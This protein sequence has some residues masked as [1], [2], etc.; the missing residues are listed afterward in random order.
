MLLRMLVE[1]SDRTKLLNNG[2]LGDTAWSYQLRADFPMFP[3]S[4]LPKLSPDVVIR[5]PPRLAPQHFHPFPMVHLNL[6][7]N[8]HQT[9]CQIIVVFPHQPI[10]ELHVVDI[11]EYERVFGRVEVFG[12]KKCGGVI[13]PVTER[14]E[15]VRGVVAIVETIAV[16]LR[17]MTGQGEL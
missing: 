4:F 13:T 14:V 9:R 2:W 5:E 12:F 10:R 11:T 3:H 8:R 15:M 1:V 6:V 7:S 16:A 17:K